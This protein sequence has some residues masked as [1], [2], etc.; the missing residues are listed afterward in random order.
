MVIGG[1]GGGGGG[2]AG[3]S[4]STRNGGGGGGSSSVTKGLFPANLLPDVLYILVGSGGLGG[5]SATTGG[6]GRLSYVS[7]QPNTILSN[8][9]LI[10]T[11]PS[12]LATGGATSG[13]GN[14][15]TAFNQSLAILSYYGIVESNNGNQGGNPG[16]GAGNTETQ[17]NSITGGGAPGAGSVSSSN[18]GGSIA[19]GLFTP[20]ISGGAAGRNSGNPGVF[21]QLP[22]IHSISNAPLYFTGGSGGGSNNA[23]IGGAGGNG[24]YGS[25]GGGGGAGTTGG[26]GGDGGNGIVIITSL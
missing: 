13:G 12:F 16:S 4:G 10:S 24:S 8:L 2:Q 23:G 21:S 25:G 14:G 15:G 5:A 20:S 7:S 18:I 11:N 1:G 19:Q 9:V 6:S 26:S 22:S 17:D 3:L